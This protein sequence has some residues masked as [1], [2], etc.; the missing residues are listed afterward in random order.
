MRYGIAMPM[1]VNLPFRQIG[2]A[3]LKV[4]SDGAGDIPLSMTGRNPLG[5]F[6][7]W[8][9]ARPWCWRT[10]EPMLR[11][12]A[13]AESVATTLQHALQSFHGRSMTTPRVEPTEERSERA[14]QLATAGGQ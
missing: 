14:P 1:T 10:P 12:V 5:F 13:D 11:A 4:Y 6:H 7:L 8:P 3:A 2:S 9:H